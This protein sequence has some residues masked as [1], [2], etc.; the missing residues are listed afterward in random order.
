M[1]RF[2]ETSSSA[3]VCSLLKLIIN[4]SSRNFQPQST[5]LVT[6]QDGRTNGTGSTAGT[7]QRGTIPGPTRHHPTDSADR[8]G[9]LVFPQKQKEGHTD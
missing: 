9:R 6:D 8:W 4:F 3:T 5:I 7:G 2:C 1:I